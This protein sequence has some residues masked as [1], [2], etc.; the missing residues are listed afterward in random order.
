VGQKTILG[1]VRRVLGVDDMASGSHRPSI[2]IIDS[3]WETFAD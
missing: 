2:P 1:D 3:G